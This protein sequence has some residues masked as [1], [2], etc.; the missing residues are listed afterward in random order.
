MLNWSGVLRGAYALMS[1]NPESP[2]GLGRGARSSTI[3]RSFSRPYFAAWHP[4]WHAIAAVVAWRESRL[5]HYSTVE[6]VKVAIPSYAARP[7]LAE[8]LKR[9]SLW[10][11][12]FEVYR[13]NYGAYQTAIRYL[14]TGGLFLC[15]ARMPATHEGWWYVMNLD[16]DYHTAAFEG[17]CV[18]AG[19]DL[20][21]EAPRRSELRTFFRRYAGAPRPQRAEMVEALWTGTPYERLPSDLVAVWAAWAPLQGA[22]SDL[23]AQRTPAALPDYFRRPTTPVRLPLHGMVGRGPRA[24]VNEALAEWRNGVSEAAPSRSRLVQV[25][26]DGG[27]TWWDH[28]NPVPDWCGIFVA[29]AGYRAGLRPEMRRSFWAVRSIDDFFRGDSRDNR[30]DEYPWAA[31][32]VWSE[33]WVPQ[34]MR[35]GDILVTRGHVAIIKSV[36]DVMNARPIVCTVEGNAT[37]GL[38]PGGAGAPRASDAVVEKRYSS[39]PANFVGFG[40]FAEDDFSSRP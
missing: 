5:T 29:A 4:S 6:G 16:S 8:A 11:V 15:G 26:E 27:W 3:A 36:G 35:P 20:S 21:G 10:D 31:A 7:H 32:R 17:W 22:S 19:Y 30:V 25:F 23:D 34:A 40:R 12:P 14:P 24:M 2:S 18:Q 37:G 33:H 38:F 1:R 39:R 13:L 9:V 28:A